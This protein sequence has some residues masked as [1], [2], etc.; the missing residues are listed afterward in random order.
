MKY[1]LFF[2]LILAGSIAGLLSSF[3]RE[4]GGKTSGIPVPAAT[5]FTC[6]LPAPGTFEGEKTG[7]A[8]AYL[9]WSTVTDATAYR[10]RVYDVNSQSLVSNTIEYGNSAYL[11]NLSSNGHYRCELASICLGGTTSDFIIVADILE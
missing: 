3:T 2:L 10:L 1:P 4:S 9:S 5:A 6:S 11:S 8:T 7:S